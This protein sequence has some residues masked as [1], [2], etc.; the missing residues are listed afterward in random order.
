MEPGMFRSIRGAGIAAAVVSLS[1]GFASARDVEGWTLVD[2]GTL[3]GPGSY[4]A[5]VSDSGIVVGCADVDAITAHAFI[6]RDGVM[7]DMGAGCALAVND[8]GIAAGR[9]ADGDLVVWDGPSVMNL[10]VRGNV[11]GINGAGV[12]VGSFAQ[13]AATRA[14]MFANGALVPIGDAGSSSA[15]AINARGEI[16]GASNGVAFVYRA[17]SITALGTLGGNNS[18][19]KGIN[20]AG[21]L[22]GLS[23]DA[24]GQP[25]S[26]LYD[27]E[28]KALQAPG[29][30]GAIAIN[31]RGQ[32]VG[33][34]EGSGGYLLEAGT[35]TRLD[36]LTPVRALG[37]RKL[38]PTGINNRG[39]IVGTGTNP[40]GDLRAFLLIP[41]T[42]AVAMKPARHPVLTVA[43]ASRT[44]TP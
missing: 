24:N 41:G 21:Q 15:S 7:R 43:R 23:T 5:A 34:A 42:T 16:A 33:S 8:Q 6:H 40:E 18:D 32:V 37:W 1:L 27:H 36:T 19:A 25:L 13:G 22:V 4:G 17:G 12:V 28:M 14:F 9:S 44:S 35:Y 30:S 10:G 38:A 2:L 29:Y 39:W 3:G 20:D 31:N 26:F 11:G